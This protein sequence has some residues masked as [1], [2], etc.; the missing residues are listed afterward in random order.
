VAVAMCDG[1]E[2]GL[3]LVEALMARGQMDD[4]HLAHAVR[5]D[6]CRRLARH[7]DAI[8]AYRRAL[9]LARQAPERRFL[10]R[11]L[12]ELGIHQI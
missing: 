9:E 3:S 4:Y 8:S 7:D 6:L 10:A 2:S 12:A 1:P 5:G 11:R